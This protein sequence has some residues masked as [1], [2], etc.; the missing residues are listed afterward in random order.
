MVWTKER[1]DALATAA[2]RQLRF[3]AE[4]LNDPQIVERCD[5]VLHERRKR[6]AAAAREKS[7]RSRQGG[8]A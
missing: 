6:V 2:V 5:G 4:R 3:N 1:I 8:A 7:A